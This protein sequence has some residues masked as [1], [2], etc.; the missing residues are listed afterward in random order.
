MYKDFGI[1]CFWS[2]VAGP[3]LYFLCNGEHLGIRILELVVFGVLLQVLH[4]I[5]CV[6]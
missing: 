2:V 4:S 6:T 5:F 3:T 1:A